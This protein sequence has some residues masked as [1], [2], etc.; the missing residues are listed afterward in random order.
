MR[1]KSVFV[2][3]PYD[4][5]IEYREILDAEFKGSGVEFRYADGEIENAHVMNKIC[6]MMNEA[7]VCM[8][9][10][11]GNNPNV[12]FELGYALGAKEPGFVVVHVDAVK[13]LS[14][15]LTGW[16]QLRYLNVKDLAQKLVER[17]DK[18]RIPRKGTGTGTSVPRIVTKDV[19]RELRFGIPQSGEP[20]LAVY[21]VP[22][23]YDRHYR[24]GMTIGGPPFSARQLCD[25]VF[26]GL[27]ET[28]H[29]TYF[30]PDHFDYDHVPG[31]GFVEVYD[32]ERDRTVNFRLYTSGAAMYM[33]QLR[34]G[35]EDH[36]PFLYRYMFD[37]IVEMALISIAE[38]RYKLGFA[39]QGEVEVGALFLNAEELRVSE[40]TRKFYPMGDGGFPLLDPYKELWIPPD[41]IT[42]E[43]SDLHDKAKD[44]ASDMSGYLHHGLI[45]S[46]Q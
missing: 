31:P 22:K 6:R 28:Q 9:D 27:N 45:R 18:V 5:G 2:A 38:A 32:D 29:K 36:K 37:E 8:F 1:V 17:V 41:P 19:L 12:M 26:A 14:A 25:P 24:D 44:L 16:D 30:W 46:R 3:Y 11:T 33:Q 21:V 4:F 42:V 20:V 40:A 34:E 43:S 7:D 39:S 10:V 35:G 13:S 23:D 15:D